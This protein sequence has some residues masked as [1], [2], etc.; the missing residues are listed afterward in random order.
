MRKA[1][2]EE[3]MMTLG[4]HHF[5]IFESDVRSGGLLMISR[6]PINTGRQC[7]TDQHIDVIVETVNLWRL[8]VI[9]G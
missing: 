1:K 9:Y 6:N 4:F 5:L 3:L 7:V 8:T 2:V